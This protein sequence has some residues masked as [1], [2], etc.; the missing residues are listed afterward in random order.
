MQCSSTVQ[1]EVIPFSEGSMSGTYTPSKDCPAKNNA[2][3]NKKNSNL[4]VLIPTR[5]KITLNLLSY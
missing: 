2:E 3:S 4:A 5:L 1:E